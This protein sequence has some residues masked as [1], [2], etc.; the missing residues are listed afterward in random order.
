MSTA[1]EKRKTPKTTKSPAAKQTRVTHRIETITPEIA[2]S[3][4][5]KNESNRHLDQSTVDRYARDMRAGR[6]HMTGDPIQFGISGRLLNGQHR[7]WGCIE[8]DTPFETMVIR[9]LVNEIEIVDV[10][11]TGKKRTLGNALQIHGEKDALLLAAIINHCWRFEDSRMK[12]PWPTH[13][14]GLEWLQ[15]NPQVREATTMARFVYKNLKA[16]ASA[17]GTAYYLNSRI[18]ADAAEDFWS[19]AATGELLSAGDPIL[20]YRRWAVSAISKREKPA[21]NVWLAYGLKAMNLW[22]KKRSVRLLAV[23]PDE[24]MPELW[25]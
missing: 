10:I 16:Q 12:G 6:W 3:W 20:A 24:G 18:D 5:E 1:T 21:P 17:V 25:S 7:L 14:E 11:D 9:N 2:V 4:L 8:A 22:R 23:K 15:D 13:E 19:K